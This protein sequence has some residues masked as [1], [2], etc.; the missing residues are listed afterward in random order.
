MTGPASPAAAGAS[1]GESAAGVR[2]FILTVALEPGAVRAVRH[3][4]ARA[5]VEFGFSEKSA[6]VDSVLLAVS[7]LVANV[8]RHAAGRTPGADV[9]I[10]AGA[11]FLVIG[12]ADEDPRVPDLSPAAIGEGLRT[13]SELAAAYGGTLTVRPSPN[14]DGK[15]MTVRFLRPEPR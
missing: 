5:L 9:T 1:A 2:D 3:D 7:E 6:F 8:V 13:V 10:K 12:V 11:E 4:V 14:G 15:T